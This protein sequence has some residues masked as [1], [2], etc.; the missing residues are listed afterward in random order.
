MPISKIETKY[1]F[2]PM[3][4]CDCA[5]F[6]SCCIGSEQNEQGGGLDLSGIEDGHDSYGNASSGK[7]LGW[8]VSKGIGTKVHNGDT[9]AVEIVDDYLVMGDIVAY[10]TDMNGTI[11]HVVIYLGNNEVAG[12]APSWNEDSGDWRLGFSNFGYE[13]YHIINE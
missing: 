10:D 11:N 13:F 8:L 2:N 9:P 5:H 3:A 6:V 4:Y 7:L 12:H 1:G